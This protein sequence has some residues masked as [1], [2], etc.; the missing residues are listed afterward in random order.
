M[1]IM[2][3]CTVYAF[4]LVRTQ[5]LQLVLQTC[6]EVV[7][8]GKATPS[9]T[10]KLESVLAILCLLLKPF[11]CALQSTALLDTAAV[12]VAHCS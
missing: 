7:V 4:L 9:T 10:C 6:A 1:D 2:P 12:A 8:L 5:L 3:W 11:C